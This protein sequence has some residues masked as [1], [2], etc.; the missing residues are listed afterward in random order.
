MIAFALV[1]QI[2]WL[3]SISFEISFWLCRIIILRALSL[4]L[5]LCS[6]Y[7]CCCYCW[8]CCCCR[9]CRCYFLLFL[10]TFSLANAI[11]YTC[12]HLSFM[13]CAAFCYQIDAAEIESE[14]K[15]V[16]ARQC[17]ATSQQLT[18]KKAHIIIIMLLLHVR[19]LLLFIIWLLHYLFYFVSFHFISFH[20][21]HLFVFPFFVL[22]SALH[23]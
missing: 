16:N 1:H 13:K 15:H 4:L 7:Y 9:C 2:R 18:L 11:T 12:H 17:E 10:R 3:S 8:C 22:R 20:F 21:A 5:L 14:R 6:C 19:H 23:S